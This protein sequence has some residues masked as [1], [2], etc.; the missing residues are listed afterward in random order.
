M[1]KL[2]E[3]LMDPA[4]SGVYRVGRV[5]EV[6]EAAGS[7]GLDVSRIAAPAKADLLQQMA[8][9]LAFPNWFGGNWDA[10][11]DC[12]IDLSWREAAGYVLV[13]E[14]FQTLPAEDLAILL[15][16]LRSAAAF[17]ADQ[18]RPFF[19]VFIDPSRTLKVPDLFRRA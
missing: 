2:L 16:V 19:A 13:L 7:S 1:S 10:L 3:R 12:L 9:Q 17:W 6:V 15:D 14:E 5:D 18:G 8:K 4:R 11:E